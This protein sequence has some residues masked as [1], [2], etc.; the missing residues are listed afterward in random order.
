MEQGQIKMNQKQNNVYILFL[1]IDGFTGIV[2]EKKKEIVS[3]M[4]V[5]FRQY[6]ELCDQYGVLKIETVG[7]TYLCC[8]GVQMYEDAIQMPSDLRKDPEE[9]L[10]SMYIYIFNILLQKIRKMLILCE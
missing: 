4:D 7:P 8:K 2:N 5:L 9:K 3:I 1:Y 10:I 6:D